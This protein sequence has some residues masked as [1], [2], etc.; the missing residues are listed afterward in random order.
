MQKNDE[1]YIQREEY[2][3]KYFLTLALNINVWPQSE[4]DCDGKTTDDFYNVS[5]GW[6]GWV[7]LLWHSII[8][9]WN[10]EGG[11]KRNGEEGT[12][13]D[14]PTD[15]VFAKHTHKDSIAYLIVGIKISF[16]VI[17]RRG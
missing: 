13:S 6:N 9:D 2:G 12:I 1:Y 17:N 3:I 8:K 15:P 7:P 5:H 14:E 16:A 11:D 10:G 4:E